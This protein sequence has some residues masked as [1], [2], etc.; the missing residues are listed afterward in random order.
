VLRSAQ[1][2][3]EFERH[4]EG[5]DS[6]K[7]GMLSSPGSRELAQCGWRCGQANG[8]EDAGGRSAYLS[9]FASADFCRSAQ[10]DAANLPRNHKSQPHAERIDSATAVPILTKIQPSRFY[11]FKPKLSTRTKPRWSTLQKSRAIRA[12][13]E[14]QHTHIS[15]AWDYGK[16]EWL[17][18]PRVGSLARLALER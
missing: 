11:A 5:V 10:V 18:S 17:R 14:Q 6:Y 13:T 1:R 12:R 4:S 3:E 16:M 15:E 7:C 9:Q 2:R 8:N